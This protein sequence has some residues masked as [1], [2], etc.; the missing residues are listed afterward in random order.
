MSDFESE[1]LDIKID[2]KVATITFDRADKLN[3]FNVSMMYDFVKA[4]DYCDGNDAVGAVVITGDGRAFCAGADISSGADGF[5][6][7]ENSDVVGP[8]GQINYGAEQVRDGGGHITLRMFD[9]KKPLIGAI[10]GPAVGMGS[11]MLLPMDYRIASETAKFGFVFTRRGIVAESASSYF[12]PRLVGIAKATDWCLS[13]RVFDAHEALS[14]GLVSAVHSPDDLL[15]AAYAIAEDIV[16]NT[17]PVS[18]ALTRQL[19]W[20]GLG[21]DHPMEAH[22]FESR[23]VFT[24]ASSAD[25]AEGVA[26]FLEKRPPEFP[27]APSRDMPDFYPWW[28]ERTYS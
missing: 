24:R 13:G 12:L 9:M 15:G 23:G 28:D 25:A 5:A 4:L 18:V 19:L 11:T 26:S 27:M 8:D 6:D 20:K 22:R 7:I 16:S 14:G 10:N 21:W 2:S 1:Y 3:A 17:A